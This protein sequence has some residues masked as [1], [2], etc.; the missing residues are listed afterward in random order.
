MDFD[1]A[2]AHSRIFFISIMVFDI[3]LADNQIFAIS[4]MVFDQAVAVNLNV[5]KEGRFGVLH[6]FQ[7]LRSYHDEIETRN[8]EEIPFSSQLSILE[9]IFLPLLLQHIA[10]FNH[11]ISKTHNRWRI[12]VSLLLSNIPNSPL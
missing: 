12:R 9:S 7:Q 2:V 5:L 3:P 10:I 4:I 6:R 11:F 1:K 8:R